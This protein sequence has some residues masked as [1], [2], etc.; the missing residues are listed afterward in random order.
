M[1][2]DEISANLETGTTI[3]ILDNR[4]SFKNGHERLFSARFYESE[5]AAKKV[6]NSLKDYITKDYNV[7][8]I[9]KEYP[10]INRSRKEMTIKGLKDE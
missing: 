4:I 8:I 3:A 5:E 6:W 1:F 2:K 7:E 9:D 10:A